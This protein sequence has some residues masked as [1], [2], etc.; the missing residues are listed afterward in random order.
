[1]CCVCV[2]ACVCVCVFVWQCIYELQNEEFIVAGH[3][4]CLGAA[5]VTYSSAL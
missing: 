4:A 2:C 5:L 1:M 3:K